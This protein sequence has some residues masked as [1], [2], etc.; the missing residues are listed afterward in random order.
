V[1]PPTAD[2]DGDNDIVQLALAILDEEL[3]SW[4]KSGHRARV[5]QAP[6]VSEP[7]AQS[8]DSS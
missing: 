3:G 1:A 4:V 2:H 5:S 8:R 6:G 7:N